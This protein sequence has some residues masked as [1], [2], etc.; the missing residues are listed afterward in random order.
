[1]YI[2]THVYICMCVHIYIYM[3]V[4]KDIYLYIYAHTNIYMDLYLF[5]IFIRIHPPTRWCVW[6]TCWECV[7]HVRVHSHWCAYV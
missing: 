7:W 3:Y 6:V 1:M 5:V 2:H 4:H